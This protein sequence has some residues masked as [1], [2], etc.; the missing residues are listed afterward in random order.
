MQ[1]WVFEVVHL[2][3]AKK[4][5]K[6]WQ[7]I[8]V[9]PLEIVREFTKERQ[10]PTCKSHM[11]VFAFIGQLANGRWFAFRK[12]PFLVR[13]GEL[14]AI[15]EPAQLPITVTVKAPATPVEPE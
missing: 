15:L 5:K 10:C 9:P 11:G 14:C 1:K 3:S 7:W 13:D 12:P 6:E 8:P 4:T 2:V